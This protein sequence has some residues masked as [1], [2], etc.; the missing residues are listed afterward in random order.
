MREQNNTHAAGLEH[1]ELQLCWLD[2]QAYDLESKQKTRKYRVKDSSLDMEN[3]A[4]K[5]AKNV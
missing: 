1:K 5:K 2:P 4:E 3:I